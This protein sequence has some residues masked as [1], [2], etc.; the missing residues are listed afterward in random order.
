MGALVQN[1]TYILKIKDTGANMVICDNLFCK[2]FEVTFYIKKNCYRV[3]NIQKK[4]S[5]D[6]GRVLHFADP[7][8][9]NILSDVDAKDSAHLRQDKNY[10]V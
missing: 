1:P 2:Y 3:K 9:A 10:Y 7:S 5:R 4:R 8:G 6:A